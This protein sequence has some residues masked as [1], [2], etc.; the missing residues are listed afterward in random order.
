MIAVNEQ[1][2][3][4]LKRM[5]SNVE[6]GVNGIIAECD[7]IVN[8]LDG[9]NEIG[10][11]RKSILNVVKSILESIQTVTAPASIVAE[12]LNAK[13]QEYQAFIDGDQFS[14]NTGSGDAGSALPVSNTSGTSGSAGGV[15]SGPSD[16]KV[17]PAVAE[18]MILQSG[19]DWG[20]NLSEEELIAVREYTGNGYININKTLRGID[21]ETFDPGR[22]EQAVA[23][24]GALDRAEI[25]CDCTVYRGCSNA[26]FGQYE[27]LPD[28]QLKGKIISDFGFMSTSTKMDSAFQKEVMLVVDVPKGAKG[29]YVGYVGTCKHYENEVL[30][31]PGQV[32]QVLNVKRDRWGRRIAHV[33]ML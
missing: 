12:K 15:G 20:N 14:F 33:R 27:N 10:V 2:V 3:A 17:D 26:A 13:A 16:N 18:Q 1:G 11:H 23:L 19:L 7:S 31:H 25:P 6:T 22:E 5:A 8:N 4:A 30:F 28:D 9:M 32:M 29:A 21:G 24:M